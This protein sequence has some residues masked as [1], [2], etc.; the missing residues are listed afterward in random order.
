M[1]GVLPGVISRRPEDL[2]VRTATKLA[3]IELEAVDGER[4]RLG[5]YWR[6]RPVVLVF[7][8]HFG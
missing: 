5:S 7:I 2:R 1:A 4:R 6:E 8:R 3:D